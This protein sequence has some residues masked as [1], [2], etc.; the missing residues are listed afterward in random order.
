MTKLHLTDRFQGCLSPPPPI[1][2]AV[3]GTYLGLTWDLLLMYKVWLYPDAIPKS[4]RSREQR[5]KFTLW[6]CRGKDDSTI[7]HGIP[8][9]NLFQIFAMIFVEIS[10]ISDAIHLKIVF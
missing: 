7:G 4:S 2:N 1:F 6:L 5:Q 9:S 8:Y 3:F 10:S